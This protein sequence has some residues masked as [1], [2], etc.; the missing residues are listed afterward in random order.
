VVAVFDSRGGGR[1]RPG[2]GHSA[3]RGHEQ[4]SRAAAR[5]G[6]RRGEKRRG[7]GW[8]PPGSEREGRGNGARPAQ[9]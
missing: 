2:R 4:P 5:E 1:A 7:P 8:A 9:P 3:R 6:G